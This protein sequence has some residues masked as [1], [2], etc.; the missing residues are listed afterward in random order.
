MQQ[1]L[2]GEDL[3]RPW[4]GIRYVSIDLKLQQEDNLPV[5]EGAVIGGGANGSTGQT[6]PGV[7]P[8]SPA[9]QAGL[10]DGDIVTAVEGVKIDA[11]HPLDAV[12][13][14]FAPGRTVTLTVLRDGQEVQVQVTL[15]T[16]PADL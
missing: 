2:A 7:V 16:R 8:D 13:V 11:E 14:Q 1:S 5:S 12:L 3:A 4:I 9:A 6:E 15:G 10:R